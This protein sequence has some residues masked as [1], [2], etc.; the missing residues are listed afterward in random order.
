MTY[1]TTPPPDVE[2]LLVS[3]LSG[4]GGI[5]VWAYDSGPGQW[6]LKEVTAVQVDVRASSKQAARDRAYAARSLMLALPGGTWDAGTVHRVDIVSGPAWVPDQDG[7]P[8]YVLR[9]SLHYR[10]RPAQP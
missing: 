10:A 4:L 8:R 9:A 7:A 5:K 3:T 1:T 2:A 6:A